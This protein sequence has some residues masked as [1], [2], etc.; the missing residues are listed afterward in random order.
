MWTSDKSYFPWQLFLYVIVL[1]KIVWDKT[2]R[3]LSCF[4]YSL[5]LL[6]WLSIIYRFYFYK[7]QKCRLVKVRHVLFNFTISPIMLLYF[8]VH[9]FLFFKTI[10]FSSFTLFDRFKLEFSKTKC[11]QLLK[12]SQQNQPWFSRAALEVIGEQEKVLQDTRDTFDRT[13]A[14]FH[15]DKTTVSTCHIFLC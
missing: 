9:S 8:S 15:V 3:L 14:Y 1:G 5:L 7:I 12:N 6:I 4:A 11:E 10:D 13:T 2:L